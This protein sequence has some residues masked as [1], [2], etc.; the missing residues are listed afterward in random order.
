MVVFMYV[1][2]GDKVHKKEVYADILEDGPGKM[3]KPL[4]L[5]NGLSTI[6]MEEH[7]VLLSLD[8][9]NQLLQCEHF[10]YTNAC[11]KNSHIRAELV[12]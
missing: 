10:D 4:N 1:P 11:S 5:L 6:S 7:K 9:L 3:Q 8:R 2:S 12:D